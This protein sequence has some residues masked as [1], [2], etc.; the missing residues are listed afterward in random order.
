MNR[1]SVLDAGAATALAAD[2][3]A[4][5]GRLRLRVTGTSMLPAL[6][7][8]DVLEFQ[9]LAT[10]A[11]PGEIVLYRRGAGLV[12]HRVLSRTDS[13]LTTQ[14]DSLAAPDAPVAH[15]DVLGRVVGLRRA[16]KAVSSRRHIRS[17]SRLTRWMFRRFDLATRLFLRWHRL[18]ARAA[19]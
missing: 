10:I 5:S 18:A 16:N 2:S 7:P 4:R 19:A 6:R 12:V 9:P 3:L 17:G 11:E 13:G 8:G 1:D 14:G 15:V